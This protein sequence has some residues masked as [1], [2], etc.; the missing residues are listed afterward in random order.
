VQYAAGVNAIR[1]SLH[2]SVAPAGLL[3]VNRDIDQELVPRANLDD[4]LH[5][6]ATN[7]AT[8]KGRETNKTKSVN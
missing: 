1:S 2:E 4:V 5:K 6:R 3:I 8:T 7:G